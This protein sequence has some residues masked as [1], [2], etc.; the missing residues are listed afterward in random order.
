MF[1]H[2]YVI[3]KRMSLKDVIFYQF[4]VSWELYHNINK[5]FHLFTEPICIEYNL[6][7]T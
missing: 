1:N 4:L 7:A 6:D 5:K 2:C 3:W